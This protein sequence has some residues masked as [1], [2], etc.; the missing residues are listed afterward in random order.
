[1]NGVN[2]LRHRSAAAWIWILAAVVFSA[3]APAHD[4]WFEPSSF[5]PAPGERV[6]LH[7]RVG[8]HYT[9]EPVVRRG[10]RIESFVA[11]TP[12]GSESP[13]LGLEGREPAGWLITQQPGRYVVGYRTNTAAIELEAAKFEAYLREE[14]LDAVVAERARRGESSKPGR[15]VYSRSIKSLLSVGGEGAGDVSRPLGLTLEIVPEVDPYSLPSPKAMTVQVLFQGQP[16]AGALVH[17]F[18]KADPKSGHA[19]RTDASGRMSFAIER[20]GPWL[21]KA[22]HMIR[23]EADPRADWESLWASLVFEAGD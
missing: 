22:V 4:V 5:R 11:L 9:G 8:E 13:V 20:S 7:L 14:G 10:A 12:D 23:A 21:V 19:A 15:E 17:A 16:L 2:R 6:A 18:P 3:S 1:M